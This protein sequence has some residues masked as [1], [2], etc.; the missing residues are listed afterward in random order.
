MPQRWAPRNHV[1]FQR[2]AV[3]RLKPD[4]IGSVA[5]DPYATCAHFV[6]NGERR[7]LYGEPSAGAASLGAADGYRST[8]PAGRSSLPDSCV[9]AVSDRVVTVHA[10]E[11]G[12][13]AGGRVVEIERL[14]FVVS[15][16]RDR[17]VRVGP[18]VRRR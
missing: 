3:I 12:F 17:E 8:C 9:R 5:N 2:V 16:R 14:E 11:R 13:A 7:Q 18:A 4:R 6:G 10:R 15:W 1:S